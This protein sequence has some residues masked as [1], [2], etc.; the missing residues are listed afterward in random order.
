MPLP[1]AHESA[2]LLGILSVLN[3]VQ[4]DFLKLPAEV[5]A[6]F[7]PS[8][9]GTIVGT[10]M[11]ACLGHLDLLLPR[12]KGIAELGLTK[13]A[14]ILG[15]REGY[16]DFIH[17]SGLRLELKLAYV[18]P[19]DIPMKKPPTPREPSARITQKVTVKNVVP[20]TDLLLVVAYQLRRM[21]SD[22]N[23]ACPTVFALELFP[24]IECIA[25]RDKRL[26]DAGG[27]WF[28]NFET[29]TVLS[30]IGLRKVQEGVPLDQMSYGRKESE[31]KDY[32]EDTNFGK[33]KRIP[34]KPLQEFLKRIGANYSS[35]GNYPAEWKIED[36]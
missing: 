3:G 25:A 32:N 12:N 29:P 2:R 5:L 33:L 1:G 23:F 16:P 18:D 35:S 11:D 31:G 36:T 14:G 15:E 27:R 8:Q 17:T 20:E 19:L 10:L 9:V 28:G 30:N 26:S 34:Y 21:E 13:N 24:M 22:P 7:E 6:Q 4:L